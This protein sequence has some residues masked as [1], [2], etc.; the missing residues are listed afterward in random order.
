M[1]RVLLVDDDTEYTK[2]LKELIEGE[3]HLVEVCHNGYEALKAIEAQCF[4]VVITDIIMPNTDG[5]EV[6][7]QTRLIQPDAKIIAI[8]GGGVFKSMDLLIMAR[9][10][11]ASMVLSKPFSFSTLRIQLHS[12]N[13]VKA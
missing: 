6:I 10:L 7:Y 5:L 3:G 12:L 13:D 4:D 1:S 9:E 8:T 2:T 11:G